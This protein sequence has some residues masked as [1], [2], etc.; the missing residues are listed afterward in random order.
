M[1]KKTILAF[2][3][4]LAGVSA[5]AQEASALSVTLDVTYVSDYIFRG[6]KLGDASIQPSVEASY[7]DF[8]AGAWH[9]SEISSGEGL[10]ETD[11]YAGYGFAA[12]DTISIDAGVT[13][14]TYN[15]GSGIDST[16]LFVGAA[17]D[18]ILSPSLYV[19]YDFDL[20]NLT[21]EASIGHSFPIDA[22]NASLDLSGKVGYVD[23]E[24]SINSVGDY[25]YY[26]A[27]AS[28]P[29]KLS[30]TATLTVG[31]DYIY[32]TEDEVTAFNNDGGD[33]ILVGKVGISIGF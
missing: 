26:V 15:G 17:L 22:I 14:Y 13:Q 2:S 24:D 1:I 25:M 10:T 16:E 20:E 33:D 18:S 29:F 6:I 12:T 19:Y 7:G 5:Q 9:S 11:F 31:V 3:A 4:L 23:L 21:L 28:I 30:E 8:Y 27:G 32:N